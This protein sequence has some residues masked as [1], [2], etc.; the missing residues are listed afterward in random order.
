MDEHEITDMTVPVINE[1]LERGLKLNDLHSELVRSGIRARYARLEH[2]FNQKKQITAQDILACIP[3]LEDEPAEPHRKPTA[4]NTKYANRRNPI[5]IKH[6]ETKQSNREGKYPNPSIITA[7][8]IDQQEDL[9][10][11]KRISDDARRQYEETG[12]MLYVMKAFYQ[13][14][15]LL[16]GPLSQKAIQCQSALKIDPPSASKID[17]PQR[18]V[19][20]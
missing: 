13:W 14:V 5:E 18:L 19:F 10:I 20:V 12:N 4:Q 1:L 9:K 11:F 17:P 8:S 3:A 7:S 16:S 15:D 6:P 2:L